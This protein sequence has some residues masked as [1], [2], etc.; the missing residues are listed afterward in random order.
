MKILLSAVATGAAF[1]AASP[2]LAAIT[3][4]TTQSGVTLDFGA[5]NLS[6]HIT[7]DGQPNATTL[8]LPTDDAFRVDFTAPTVLEHSGNGG[9]ASMD[10][11]GNGGGETGFA[12]IVIDPQAPNAGFTAI[13]FSL[14]ALGT[15]S[16]TYYGDFILKQL[17]GLPDITFENVAIG[18]GGVTHFGI[19]SLDN[20]IFTSLELSGLR[21]LEI[22]GAAVNFESL[23][24]VSIQPAPAPAVPEPATW[25]LMILG[26]GLV[27]GAMRRRTT[28]FYA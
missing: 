14:K 19:S 28:L 10:G 5:G 7:D 26:F 21:T 6:N 22:G 13:N 11:P 15:G 18:T 8:S 20:R 12:S 24:Q 16:N 4:D 2:A 3:I 25:A 23:R 9:F 27:G 17:S 1:G